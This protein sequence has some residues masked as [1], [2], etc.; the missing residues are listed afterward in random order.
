MSVKIWLVAFVFQDKNGHTYD[1]ISKPDPTPWKAIK[2]G[3]IS[4]DKNAFVSNID[5]FRDNTRLD[6]R[7]YNLYFLKDPGSVSI[8]SETQAPDF[9]SYKHLEVSFVSLRCLAVLDDSSLFFTNYLIWKSYFNNVYTFLSNP[10]DKSN[11]FFMIG[12][13]S[14]THLQA[15]LL[16]LKWNNMAS[17][18]NGLIFKNKSGT[19][20]PTIV[21]VTSAL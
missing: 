7:H 15:Y 12:I 1:P 18:N 10:F 8:F 11:P 14:Y 5:N 2:Q 3:S 17:R 13:E 21:N 20:I 9:F 16:L 4:L 6:G 19:V